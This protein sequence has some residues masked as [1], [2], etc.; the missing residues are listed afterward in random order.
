MSGTDSN[1]TGSSGSGTHRLNKSCSEPNLYGPRKRILYEEAIQFYNKF[2]ENGAVPVAYDMKLAE[3]LKCGVCINYFN[4]PIITKC[5]HTFC[6]SCATAKKCLTCSA[7]VGVVQP[8]IA[9]IKILEEFRLTCKFCGIIVKKEEADKHAVLC[10]KRK[11]VCLIRG[12]GRKIEL[13]NLIEHFSDHGPFWKISKCHMC[14]VVYE[15]REED[16]NLYCIDYPI[17][18][19]LCKKKMSRGLFMQHSCFQEMYKNS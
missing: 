13:D 15:G 14:K 2:K 11:V 8:N 3:T 5:N 10:R 16:H 18:C 17:D 12:C 19:N 6:R 1:S 7:L 9:M 4:D